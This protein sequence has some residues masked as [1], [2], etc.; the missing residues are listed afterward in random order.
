[1]RNDL[2]ILLVEWEDGGNLGKAH[3]RRVE[4]TYQA[5]LA[6]DTQEAF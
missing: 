5:R 3:R 6:N 4:Q 1:M 2:P